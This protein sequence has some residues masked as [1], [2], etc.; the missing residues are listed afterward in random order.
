MKTIPGLFL[1]KIL[2]W[3]IKN[4]FPEIEKSIVL[5]ESH[6]DLR[7]TFVIDLFL[8]E[9][10]IKHRFLTNE[11]VLHFPINVLKYK[12]NEIPELSI[13][14][15]VYK[16]SE[17]LFFSHNMHL[18]VP[19]YYKY[20]NNSTIANFIHQLSVKSNITVLMISVDFSIREI[21][22]LRIIPK[23]EFDLF[24]HFNL[25]Y[26]DNFNKSISKLMIDQ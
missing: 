6:N 1:T 23:T 2:G 10:K 12:Y 21:G 18:V 9:Y 20:S 25:D 15:F 4:P 13:T 26:H 7:E 8:K 11:E 22:V 3:N 5:F 24:N 14:E 16:I 17:I 19:L